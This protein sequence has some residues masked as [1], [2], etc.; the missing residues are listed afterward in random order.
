[1]KTVIFVILAI[2]GYSAGSAAAVY[3]L[4]QAYFESK[5]ERS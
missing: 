2:I 1:M 5:D 4:V 3:I